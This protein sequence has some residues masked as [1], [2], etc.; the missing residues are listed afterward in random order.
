MRL[1]GCWD[2]GAHGPCFPDC[3]CAKCADPL[4][5]AQWRRD[6]PERYRA[7][8]ASQRLARAEE[9]PCPMCSLAG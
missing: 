2:C 9:C 6:H 4:G 5:Y 7:W 1:Q 8:V 3:L